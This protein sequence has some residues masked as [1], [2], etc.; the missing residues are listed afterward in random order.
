MGVEEYSLIRY[1]IHCRGAIASNYL[2][3]SMYEVADTSGWAN[4]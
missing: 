2:F 1:E 4:V 3:L